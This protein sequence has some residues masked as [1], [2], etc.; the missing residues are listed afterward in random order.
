MKLSLVIMLFFVLPFA[1]KGQNTNVDSLDIGFSS[2]HQSY[3]VKDKDAIYAIKIVNVDSDKLKALSG[4]ADYNV[5]VSIFS[6]STTLPHSAVSLDGANFTLKEISN[7]REHNLYL[8]LKG[9]SISDRERNLFLKIDISKKSDTSKIYYVKAAKSIMKIEIKPIDK[10][11]EDY[12]VLAYLGSNFD[13]A[14]GKTSLSNLFFAT[15]IFVPPV[16]ERQNKVG[17]YLSLYGNR[18]MTTI[19]STGAIDRVVR[20]QRA[21]D[22]TYWQYTASRKLMTTTISDNFGAY[23]SPLFRLFCSKLKPSLNVYIAPSLEFVWR[24]THVNYE[25]LSQGNVDSQLINSPILPELNL[26]ENIRKNIN[27]YAFNG[28]LGLF[29]SYETSSI[30]V[31]VHGSVGYSSFFYPLLNKDLSDDGTLKIDMERQHDMFFSGRAWIT[32]P[33]TGIT[34]QAEVTNTACKPRPFFGATLSK[35]FKLKSLG[36]I[37]APITSRN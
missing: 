10:P 23:I 6:D 35:A 37:L 1:S 31:R 15:N 32:E 22:S 30:S 7:K 8:T 5:K 25:F 34:L 13:M 24:R 28:G 3:T 21:S 19:D 18:T 12:T 33:V 9:D 36:G 14:E 17:F 4:L 2:L 29:L 26:D 20:V 16:R 11:I 27:E